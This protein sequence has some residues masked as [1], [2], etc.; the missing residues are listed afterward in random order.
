MTRRRLAMLFCLAALVGCALDLAGLPGVGDGTADGGNPGGPDASA[1]GSVEGGRTVTVPAGW[2]LVGFATNTDAGCPPGLAAP[3]TDVL[4][5]PS[6]DAGSCGC[7]ACA[8]T[9]APTCT[10]KV[11]VFFDFDNLHQCQFPGVPSQNGNSPAGGC[12]NDMFT[13]NEIAGTETKLVP[14]PPGGGVCASPG[15][16]QKENLTYA[17]KGRVCA[18]ESPAAAGCA[19]STCAPNLPAPFRACIS[20]AGD[21]PCPAGD[22]SVKHL[23]GTDVSATCGAC[24]CSV[25]GTCSGSLTMY[26]DTGCANN[27]EVLTANG[28]CLRN[29]AIDGNSYKS[30]RYALSPTGVGCVATGVAPT[31]QNV[32]LLSAQTVCCP[33]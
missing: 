31:A 17:A 24:G 16:F 18:P 25:T 29:A 15:V 28:Q 27:P 13:A 6:A 4:E 8:V 30:Y 21:R 3:A 32:S 11:N 5:G 22:F 2:T 7:A 14:T 26:S 20:Q 9:T 1:D 33:P 23:V 10:G 12:L 19:G